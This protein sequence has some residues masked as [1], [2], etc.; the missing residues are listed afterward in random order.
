MAGFDG[1]ED[2]IPFAF[3]VRAVC[4]EGGVEVGVGEDFFTFGDVFGDGDADAHGYDAQVCDN[5]HYGAFRVGY[6][7]VW[8]IVGGVVGG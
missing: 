8:V 5:V 7:W 1:V 3:D 4:V 2:G 6:W